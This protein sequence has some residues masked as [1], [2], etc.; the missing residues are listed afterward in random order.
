MEEQKLNEIKKEMTQEKITA[1][2]LAVKNTLEKL[3]LLERQKNEVQNQIK[4][5]KHDLFDLKD[6]RLDRILERQ[7]LNEEIKSLSII[8]VSKIEEGMQASPWYV[9]YA[10]EIKNGDKPVSLKLNNSVTKM[11]AS[12][13]YKLVDGTIRYL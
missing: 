3:D 9:D 12:G 6:G 2:K 7:E 11:H 13:S 5:L 10:I 8:S 4:I 1:I